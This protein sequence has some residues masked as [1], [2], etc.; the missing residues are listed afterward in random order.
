[1]KELLYR[2]FSAVRGDRLA[3]Q[4]SGSS[5]RIL[6]YHGVC[7]DRFA[8]ERW[9]PPSFVSRSSFE[10]Q[11]AYLKQNTHVLS[12]SKAVACLQSGG[13]PQR[14]VAITLDDGYANNLHVAYPILEKYGVPATIFLTT[15]HAET[16]EF[17][18]FDLQR[19]LPEVSRPDQGNGRPPHDLWLEES[20]NSRF[21]QGL[22][23]TLRPLRV[24]EIEKWNSELIEF[25]AHTHRHA[26]L[27]NESLARREWE[28]TMS[29]DRVHEWAGRPVKFF[30]YPYG[31]LGDFGELD[32][33][34]L[35]S[36]GIQAAVTTIPG[37]NRAGCDLFGLRRYSIGLH[38]DW[39]AF[40]AEL[41]GFRSLVNSLAGRSA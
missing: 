21:S 28:I 26:I 18:P 11:I 10:R 25:G 41:T 34:M 39:G 3:F 24:D 8:G 40:L 6:T 5:L 2:S 19:V 30:S 22:R 17:Y 29:V 15:S 16:G 1:M 32:K 20:T 37:V 9:V 4:L 31:G 36:N 12:L 33:L 35:R 27:R 13:L 38:H 23:E 14:S 7:E